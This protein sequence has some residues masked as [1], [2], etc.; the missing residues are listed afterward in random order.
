MSGIFKWKLFGSYKLIILTAGAIIDI[1][2]FVNCNWVDTR[3]QYTF[4]HKQ[5]IEHH[6]WQQNNTNNK[7]NNTNNKFGTNNKFVNI[8][9]LQPTRR[10]NFLKFYFGMKLYMFRM[11]LRESCLQIC[12]TYTTAVC[13]VRNSWWWTKELSETC[14]VSFQNKI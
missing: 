14:R 5:Y 11:I 9:I 2:I 6:N 8:L 7:Q 12:M 4:T 13:T 10:T 3:W 1:D